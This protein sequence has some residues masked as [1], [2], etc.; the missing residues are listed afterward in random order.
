[1]LFGLLFLALGFTTYFIL[2]TMY[3]IEFG[4]IFGNSQASITTGATDTGTIDT[5][6]INETDTSFT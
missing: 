5:G 2:K 4:N 3:P 6:I 1:M